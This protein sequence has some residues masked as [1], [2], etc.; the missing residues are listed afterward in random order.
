[1]DLLRELLTQH[2]YL[3]VLPVIYGLLISV[4][5]G[6][7]C[8][9]WPRLYPPVLAVTSILYALPSIALFVF[10]LDYTGLSSAT[11][12]IPL[13]A[14]TLSILVRNV[15]DGLRSVPDSTRQSAVAMGFSPTRRLVQIELP[16]ATPIVIAGVR[17]ATVA[18][19]SLVTVGS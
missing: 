17:I 10:L 14:Y 12:I 7:A 4:P 15:V 16:I 18:N 13:T 1:M 8:A 2:V 6:V 19:I 5:L 3:A 9:H 11:V